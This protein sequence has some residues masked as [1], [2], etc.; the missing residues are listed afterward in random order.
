MATQAPERPVESPPAQRAA[1][2]AVTARMLADLRKL[3]P[4][5]PG[6]AKLQPTLRYEV[7]PAIAKQYGDAAAALAADWYD[8]QRLTLGV[9]GSFK[10][11]LAPTPAEDMMRAVSNWVAAPVEAPSTDME[12]AL[13]RAEAATQKLVA[14]MH[15][16]T[17]QIS[18]E[19]DPNA[20]GW[21]RFTEP[22]ACAFCLM[23]SSR[24][25]VYT[26]ASVRFGSH[27]HC[28]CLAGPV[29]DANREEVDAYQRAARSDR[30]RTAANRLARKWIRDN[31]GG[32]ADAKTGKPLKPAQAVDS[33]LKGM[34]DQRLNHLI[35]VTDALPDT[36]Y[37]REQ[38]ARLRG[39]KK[40]RG[41]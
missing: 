21:G 17:V 23:L 16:D 8:A 10:A 38:L 6:G 31:Y 13:A 20:H 7:L 27:D 41:I 39:E 2:V 30:Q 24:G 14:D 19:R 36:P 9:P 28:H 15:R 33:G 5:L 3:W 11:D 40:R 1:L 4:H 32:G 22:G 25:G 12:T 35:G 26:S 18:T 29:W 37:K 34:T